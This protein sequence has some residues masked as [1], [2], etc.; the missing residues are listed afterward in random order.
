MTVIKADKTHLDLI[1]PLFNLYRQFYAQPSDP[2]KARDFIKE[3]LDK[4]DSVIFLALSENKGPMGFVQL[5]PSFSSVSMKRLWI[6]NDLFVA[7]KFRGKGCA[8]QLIK[9]SESY[10]QDS[11]ARGLTL[12]TA[13]DNTSAQKLYLSLDWKKDERFLSF[14]KSF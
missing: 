5:Y 3:R 12:K 8:K 10:A 6:L 13:I 2:A 7:E 11:Q 14:N 1:A 4:E 9:K